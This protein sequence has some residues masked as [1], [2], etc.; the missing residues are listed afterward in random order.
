MRRSQPVLTDTDDIRIWNKIDDVHPIDK[1]KRRNQDRLSIL[2]VI[3]DAF[4]A[5][6]H[7]HSAVL[8]KMLRKA[9][10]D[11]IS[12]LETVAVKI[13]D[14]CRPGDMYPIMEAADIVMR[15]GNLDVSRSLMKK[16]AN[17][18]DTAFREYLEGMFASRSGNN[19][20]AVRHLIRSNAIDQSFIRTYDLLI[21]MDQGKG[22]DVLRNIPLIMSGERPMDTDTGDRDLIE[23]Q[24]IYDG[25]YNGDRGAARKRLET[26]NGYTSGHLDFLL[27]AARMTGDVGEYRRAVEFYDRILVQFPNIDS[28]TVEKA[29]MLTAMGK[30]SAALA[31]LETLDKGNR[32]NRNITECT[33]KALAAKNTIKEFTSYSDPFLRSEHGD[34]DGHLLVCR[35]M[36]GI[37][38]NSEA[39]KILH[40]LMPMF[41]DDLDVHLMNAGN[42]M[43]L[44][45]DASAIKAAD[46][47]VKLSPK[48]PDGYCIRAE[49]HLKNGRLKSA[50]KEGGQALKYG[51]DHLGSLS[52]VGRARIRSGEYEK[53]LEVFR[54]IL[55]LDPGNADA[56]KEMAYAL[57]M[58]GKREEAVDEYKNALR[59][60]KDGDLMVSIMSAL[61]ENDRAD[62]AAAIAK[63]FIEDDDSADLWCLKG[64]AEYASSCFADASLSYGKALETRPHDARIWHSKGLAE[65]MAGS[66][67]EAESSYDRAVII[68]LDNSEFWLSK[69]IVQE[70][71]GDIKGAVLSLNRVIS[72]SPDNVF[73]L[74]RKARIL[75]YAGKTDEAMFFLDHALKI[76]GRNV[77]LLEIKK[78]I[79]KRNEDHEKVIGM[80]KAIL[81]VDRKNID[82][83]TD[84]AET[85]QKMGKHDEALKVLSNVSSD[86]GEVGVLMMKKNS[87]RLNGNT[88]IEIE[89][90]RSILK[91]EPDD[92]SVRLDLADALIRS[93]E[94][95]EAM[96]AYDHI[97][98]KDPKDAEVI[99]LRGKLRS[100]MGDEDSAMALYHEAV[101]EDPDNCDTLNELANAL[102]DSGEYEEASNM[103]MRAIDLSP[104]MP[105][106]HLT[107]AR[108]LLAMN[109]AEGALAALDGA[110][111]DVSESGAIYVRMGGIY[112][113]RGDLDDALTSYDSAIRNGLDDGDINFRRG[114]V[115]EMLGNREAAKKSYAVSC[116][117]NKNGVR[118]WERLGTM[119]LE[120]GEF[121]DAK[122][123]LDSAL[124]ADPFDA[125][126]LLGR[127]RLHAKEGNN[128]KAISIYR[129]LTNRD[130]STQEIEDELEEL[131][132]DA[133]TS[134]D[135][136]VTSEDDTDEEEYADEDVHIDTGEIY[137]L[138]VRVL[139]RAYETGNAASD[140]VMLSELG[141]D[142]ERRDAVLDYLSIDE[143]YGEIDIS[144]KEFERMER[145]SKNV[146]LSERRDDIDSDPLIGIPA[147]FMA[148][149]AETIDDAKR[150][151][152]YIHRAMTDDSEPFAFSQEVREAVA[153]AS[154]MSGDIS[155]YNIMI[156]F[157]VGV[158]TAR[159]I[160]RL[161][162][163]SRKGADMHI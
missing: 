98:S 61:I 93:G 105:E 82:A 140:N 63:E 45:R 52:V 138:A 90:C 69:A 20:D 156:L 77:K 72:D 160:G 10:H 153:E 41:P 126:S 110:L 94:Y 24:E 13:L 135:D 6:K 14:M 37:G 2:A 46:R 21:S 92:R 59:L 86:L 44:G 95:E 25:W 139:K 64:N 7:M 55:I 127:A 120:D 49:I 36:S 144:S 47:I 84:M 143:G 134:D 87:A 81:K 133:V 118:A 137:D 107:R 125:P 35:L 97:Q 154:E 15:E 53:G 148:S 129:T 9:A 76:D 12:D 161:A 23:L 89:A 103:I 18:P 106:I 58:L 40:L 11:G 3:D 79:Y 112:E 26:S 108:I 27:A 65:E 141:I 70:K 68:D 104:D 116:S 109:D 124:A 38:M 66:Y 117:R 102:C 123:N 54:R 28:I 33:L 75:I 152:T 128:E 147:A 74:V 145:L 114:R 22:W 159:T 85:Y 146:I 62:D 88:D 30:R 34:K 113:E 43:A 162:K 39:G 19:D 122:R 16:M 150:L 57:D 5:S 42:E 151:I 8:V 96:K 73:A 78:S 101:L 31:L 80:C 32:N 131:L 136:A 4:T 83:L 99:V 132:R 48:A 60:R 130:D 100:I 158:Y 155:T 142:G 17:V 29:N 91:L 119:Q 51:G 67:A 115:L 157:N 121:A 56:T 50:L 149:T 163:K 111:E 71:K 1:K